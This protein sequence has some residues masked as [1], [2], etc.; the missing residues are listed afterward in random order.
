M[1]SDGVAE[2]LR[3]LMLRSPLSAEEQRAV[4]HL[5]GQRSVVNTRRDRY[6]WAKR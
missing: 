4:L 1:A 5:S 6:T 2:F 3:R